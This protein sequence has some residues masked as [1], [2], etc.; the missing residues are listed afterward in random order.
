MLANAGEDTS[1]KYW[2]APSPGINWKRMPL[3]D[4][5]ALLIGFVLATTA[6]FSSA[7]EL[8]I[9]GGPA[10][11]HLLELFSSEGCSSCPPADESFARLTVRE[12]LWNQVVPVA[13]H[14][15]YW[16][17][18]GWRDRFASAPN[19]ERERAYAKAWRSS[20]VYTPCFVLNGKEWK[21]SGGSPTTKEEP[22]LLEARLKGDE[23][24]VTYAPA[25][26]VAKE[27]EVWVALLSGEEASHVTAGENSGRDLRHV[28][29][30]RSSQHQKMKRDESTWAATLPMTKDAS[31]KAIAIWVSGGL[32]EVEQAAGG[33]LRG[34]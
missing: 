9:R 17:Y 28:F 15:D 33:W 19:S 6:A 2:V 27:R 11:V 23:L 16:D 14:V 10:R 30:V 32:P 26:E 24:R 20:S 5:K 4:M 29:V 8:V 25:T 22:G 34:R 13:W 31:A 1:E 7:D 3:I 18:L 21:S 12:K